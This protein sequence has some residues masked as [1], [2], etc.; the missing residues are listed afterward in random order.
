MGLWKLAVFVRSRGGGG[1]GWTNESG[2]GKGG[3]KNSTILNERTFQV[4]P[5]NSSTVYDCLFQ[6]ISNV[7]RASVTRNCP[8]QS[9][10]WW[11]ISVTHD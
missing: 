8:S 6:R 10:W 4:S 9:K 11:S 2:K 5:K 7:L 1:K 3:V